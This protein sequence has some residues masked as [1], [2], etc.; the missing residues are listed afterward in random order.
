MRFVFRVADAALHEM[1]AGAFRVRDDPF[2]FVP[3]DTF[4]SSGFVAVEFRATD[5]LSSGSPVSPLLTKV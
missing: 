2:I 3:S 5:L 1:S 4:G